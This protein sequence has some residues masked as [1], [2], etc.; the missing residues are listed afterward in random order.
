MRY[1]SEPNYFLFQDKGLVTSAAKFTAILGD[2]ASF[3][4][5]RTKVSSFEGLR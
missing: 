4:R 3:K 5:S 2:T 1:A